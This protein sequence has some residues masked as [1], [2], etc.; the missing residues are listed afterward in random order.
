MESDDALLIIIT[1]RYHRLIP[2]GSILIIFMIVTHD[3]GLS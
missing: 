1:L 3:V 2:L